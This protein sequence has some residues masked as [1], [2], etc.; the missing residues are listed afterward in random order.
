MT[1]SLNAIQEHMVSVSSLM[2][3]RIDVSTEHRAHIKVIASERGFDEEALWR[4][5]VNET[6]FS[7]TE[8]SESFDE[9]ALNAPGVYSAWFLSRI[10]DPY[11]VPSYF[12]TKGCMRYGPELVMRL[13]MV[14]WHQEIAWA[15]RSRRMNDDRAS[16]LGSLFLKTV[17]IDAGRLFLSMCDAFVARS[18]E[19]AY[20]NSPVHNMDA[21]S[22]RFSLDIPEFMPLFRTVSEAEFSENI[23]RASLSQLALMAARSRSIE[24]KEIEENTRLRAVAMLEKARMGRM[25]GAIKQALNFGMTSNKLFAAEQ[26]FNDRVRGGHI[27]VS[28]DAGLPY[29]DFL[30][31]AKG[32]FPSDVC[33]EYAPASVKSVAFILKAPSKF[34]ETLPASYAELGSEDYSNLANWIAPY[35]RGQAIPPR[36]LQMDYGFYLVAAAFRE[37]VPP[38]L[39]QDTL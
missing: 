6:I 19:Y 15:Q 14:T 21:N 5:W 9:A 26:Q 22:I 29:A 1:D 32:I 3:Q 20:M 17:K 11:R 8:D 35:A 38:A 39:K 10:E 30:L 31:F 28:P 16:V 25:T 23:N 37:Y 7:S 13:A 4:E 12:V 2:R 34:F 24:I 36:D 33:D 18:S 27:T